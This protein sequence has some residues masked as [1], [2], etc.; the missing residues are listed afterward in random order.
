MQ[1]EI[2]PSFCRLDLEVIGRLKPALF[3]LEQETVRR[4]GKYF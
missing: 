2:P 1:F 3:G 4:K